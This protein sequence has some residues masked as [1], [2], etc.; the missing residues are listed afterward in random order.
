MNRALLAGAGAGVS[1]TSL[2]EIIAAKA[3]KRKTLFALGTNTSIDSR[4]SGCALQ[5]LVG[6]GQGLTEEEEACARARERSDGR[7]IAG[8]SRPEPYPANAYPDVD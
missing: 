8:C 7:S 1:W 3:R 4:C 6:T 5:P 2:S